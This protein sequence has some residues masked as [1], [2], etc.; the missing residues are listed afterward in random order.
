MGVPE[1]LPGVKN[2]RIW[3]REGYACHAFSPQEQATGYQIRL[4]N[5]DDGGKYRWAK[6]AVSSHLPNGELPI[7]YARPLNGQIKR[8]AIGICEGI[9]KPQIAANKL[10]QIF[11]GA[12]GFMFSKD[13]E[14]DGKSERV[15]LEQFEQYL[16][17][18]SSELG[19]KDVELYPD[20][21]IVQNSQMYQK[22]QWL[23]DALAKLGY[24]VKIAWWGQID[25]D[26]PDCDELP[27][28]LEIKRL[29]PGT[30]TDLAKKFGG[31]DSAWV[32]KVRREW[33]KNRTFTPDITSCDEFV[34]WAKPA[35]GTMFFGRAGLGSGKTTQSIKWAKEWRQ[36]DPDTRLFLPGYRNSLLYQT[37]AKMSTHISG[38]Q[39]VHNAEAILRSDPNTSFALCVDSLTK[40]LADDFDGSVIFLDE[41]MSVVKHLLHS[42]TIPNHKRDKILQLF[43]DVIRKAK[44][45]VCMDGLLAD[46]VVDYLSAIA[47]E[48]KIIKAQNTYKKNKPVINLL[49]GTQDFD[50]KIKPNDR[51]PWIKL[52][53]EQAPMPVITSDSQV[54]LEGMDKILQARGAKTLRIDSKTVPEDY[55]KEFLADCNKY[56]QEHKIDILLYSPSA[57]SG[58]DVSIPDWF[59]H[60]FGFFFGVLGVDA[61]IQMLGRIRDPKVQKFVWC[62]EWVAGSEKEH[63]K[64]PFVVDVGETFMQL[65]QEETAQSVRVLGSGGE[66]SEESLERIFAQARETIR[67]SEDIHF[68][69]SCLLKSIENAEKANLRSFLREALLKEGYG[70]N[71]VILPT[72]ED[73]KELEKEA[74]EAVKRQ[75]A[76]D[77]FTAPIQDEEIEDLASSRLQYDAKW[78]DR[79]R[80][81]KAV[82]LDRLPGIRDSGI[83]DEDFIYLT[84]Y[85][86]PDFISRQE[87]FWLY[88]HPEEAQKEG[89]RRLHWFARTDKTFIGNIR[90]RFL[91]IEAYR[92][93]EI[94]RFLDLDATWSD[95]SPEIQDLLERCKNP[96][97]AKK[98][99]HPGKM[100]GIQNLIRLLKPLGI[101]LPVSAKSRDEGKILRFYKI[102]S[103]R[104]FDPNRLAVLKAIGFRYE[105]AK[106]EEKPLDWN[107]IFKPT[108]DNLGSTSN[109]ANSWHPPHNLL[110]NMGEGATPPSEESIEKSDPE[111]VLLCTCDNAENLQ[112]NLRRPGKFLRLQKNPASTYGWEISP[113]S[114]RVGCERKWQR[115]QRQQRWWLLDCQR[116]RLQ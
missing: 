114:F 27:E 20:G 94:D 100:G 33:R 14:V 8:K 65:L 93:L 44:T 45:V 35:D 56:I 85:E 71:D 23:L 116:R 48:K 82:I 16:A 11:I 72:F 39:H 51:S 64:S 101:F 67:Q 29:K 53:L 104:F 47:P 49:V 22:S 62:K 106:L 21:G 34:N 84:K 3:G 97:I 17:A 6:G 58:V 111:Q 55:A 105:K 30:F 38:L 78:E 36:E 54:F 43:E 31:A 86:E 60:H 108:G 66:L 107:Q 102:D 25:K 37:V 61:I 40:F 113:S 87:L 42:P 70:I 28:N 98:L 50:E 75:N 77:I 73:C 109:D 12:S 88:N 89:I 74:K 57:E 83:W 81:M 103:E 1:N 9:L 2:G 92:Q 112:K 76:H 110:I 7:T 69:T 41:L 79:S 52:M 68:R 59:T 32:Q 115:W 5:P 19:T 10:G 13:G 99:G 15:L 90:S 96:A 63:T 95:S 26:K 4:E 18:A 80:R 24:K 91:K 46:W